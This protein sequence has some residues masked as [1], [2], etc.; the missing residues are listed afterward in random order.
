MNT[1]I[2]ETLL[3]EI[4]HQSHTSVENVRRTYQ[5]ILCDLHSKARIHAFIPLLA[6]NSVRT[7]F[8][9]ATLVDQLPKSNEIDLLAKQSA[10]HIITFNQKYAH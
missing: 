6:M 8:R 9:D 4:A 5:S 7:Y 3:N 2:D 10:T 1:E